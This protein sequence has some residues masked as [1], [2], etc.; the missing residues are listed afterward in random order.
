MAF[1]KSFLKQMKTA[2]REDV[3]RGDVTSN[4]LIPSK[5][6]GHAIILA[7]ES[8]IFCGVPVIRELLKLDD[9]DLQV[10]FF[11]R[12]GER[13][14]RGQDVIEL[15]GNVR[16]ILKV[17]RTLVNFLS[18]ICGIAT[19]TGAFV[20]RTSKYAVKVLDTR[21][22]TPLWRELEKYAVKAGGG[23]NHR[24]GLYDAI[25]VK[26]NHRPFGDLRR[27]RRFRNR[28]IIEVRD[29]EE[30]REAIR[31]NPRSILFDNFS[32][33]QL[34]KAV[35]WVRGRA[36]KIVL[37]ASGGIT[38]QNASRYA[39]AG[40]DQISVGSI[41]HSVKALDFSLLIERLPD[42]QADLR[43]KRSIRPSHR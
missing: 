33:A 23:V 22:T 19:T 14:R 9:P 16:S 17:E 36:P 38:L 24:M 28:F 1:S 42:R 35:R 31:L 43:A 27:L 11:I 6:E 30:L 7:K 4:T 13:F 29:F 41:T 18:W 8:G 5:A 26:E 15:K 12:D 25:L 10:K 20:K 3:G 2:L 39:S 37:E 34:K 32:P 40:V 21:K